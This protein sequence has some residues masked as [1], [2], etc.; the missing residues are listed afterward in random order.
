MLLHAV[1][2]KI[3]CSVVPV[4]LYS[5]MC[6]SKLAAK[7][8]GLIHVTIHTHTWLPSSFSKLSAPLPRSVNLCHL[9]SLH[10]LRLRTLHLLPR[11]WHHRYTCAS[12]QAMQ[13]VALSSH[14]HIIQNRIDT[15]CG[16]RHLQWEMTAP[17]TRSMP[18][19]P[20]S[21]RARH[22]AHWMR[23]SSSRSAHHQVRARARAQCH[24]A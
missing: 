19:L 5:H 15:R 14:M 9:A 1:Q 18:R 10:C 17:H 13:I 3:G 21:W 11:H 2:R 12:A 24:Q 20:G 16:P 6:C 7:W 23:L 22:P 4:P 8:Q